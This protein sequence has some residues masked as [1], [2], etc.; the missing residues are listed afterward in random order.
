MDIKIIAS[1]QI[2]TVSTHQNNRQ[3]SPV[4]NDIPSHGALISFMTLGMSSLL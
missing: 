4:A 2:G 3:C 1:K